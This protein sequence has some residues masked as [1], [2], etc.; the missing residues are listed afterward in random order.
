MNDGKTSSPACK[1]LQHMDIAEVVSL[2]KSATG[3][4]S[5]RQT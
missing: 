5:L 4:P 1:Q 2:G 3:G